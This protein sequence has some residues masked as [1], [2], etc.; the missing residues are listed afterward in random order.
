MELVVLT[1]STLA[2]LVVGTFILLKDRQS[3]TNRFFWAFTV[4]SAVW[5]ISNYFSLHQ[6]NPEASLGSIR[7]VMFFA[8]YYS[9][10]LFLT[11]HTF[12]SRT[13]LLKRWLFIFVALGSVIVSILTQ[14]SLIF[15]G[16]EGSGSNATPIAGSGI[17]LFALTTGSLILS[18]IIMLISRYIKSRNTLRAQ[19]KM[20]LI[21]VTGS[22]LLIF[23]SNFL[24]V[25]VFK[26]NLLL[27]FGPS[28]TL[29]FIIATA[30]AITQHGLF[31]IKVV[32]AEIGAAAIVLV[33]FTQLFGSE[34]A[35]D[36]VFRLIVFGMVT[37][38]GFLL[39]RSVQNEVK[40]REEVE[41]LAK[42][43][44]AALGEV[45]E[46]NKNLATLQRISDIVLNE[47]EMKTMTQ[48]ILDEIPKQLESCAG[49]LLSIVKDSQLVAYAL[50]EH[51]FGH[52]ILS[53]VGGDLE[54]YS[55][56][57]KL[58]GA[59]HIEAFPLYAGGEPFGVLM[60]VFTDSKDRVYEQNH[61]IAK[62]IS[63]D[64]SLAIQRA[65][66]YQKLKEAN[67]YLADLDKL[68]DE[69]ISM[70]SH[71]LNTP[72]A[73]I[74]GYL[75][76]VL[77]EGM[78]KI[79]P[80][81]KEYLNRAYDSSKRLA[82]LILDLL[83]VSRIE[84]GRLKMKF[85][86]SNFAS[87]VESV[88]KELQLKADTKKLYL[89]LETSKTELPETFCDPD[90]IREVFVNL[91]GNSIKFTEKGGIT[92]KLSKPDDHIR[93]EVV[94]TGRG[95]AAE[96]QSKLFQKFSQVKREIDEHQGTGLGLYISKN[97]VELHKGTIGV[98]SEVGRGATF[99]FEIPIL[100]SAPKEV[101]GAILDKPV[102]A[103]QIV[104]DKGSYLSSSGASV[105]IE[106]GP[107]GVPEIVEESSKVN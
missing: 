31:N 46:R 55:H 65:Q 64:M 2:H 68:K 16:I 15:S 20:L 37:I 34:G 9:L 72:L 49:A 101:S 14:T 50:S 12:P 4:F 89:K 24:L 97:F 10:T 33:N 82:E 69:F 75:S 52:K 63:D 36:L 61:S 79:D 45:E 102:N 67:A 7:I 19:L 96:D 18:S 100:R 44:T 107:K 11:I 21:G 91:I 28:F 43:K 51:Q 84:Q 98:K 86:K 3:Y 71:E 38:F 6:T 39:V 40:R 106:N 94:D 85:A 90:R 105:Q 26:F 57:V 13:I 1:L 29:I 77:D 62:A 78:G 81:A 92:I 42:E 74:E 88:I 66:A 23:L 104:A 83:N 70:A 47:S 99:F 59:R 60:F 22:A 27:N 48:K 17:F 35:A 58:I 30:Y 103:A 73:A 25:V 8:V 41:V 93:A 32:V 5:G 53:L 95:I 56:P 76:M 80:K 87:L 54:K